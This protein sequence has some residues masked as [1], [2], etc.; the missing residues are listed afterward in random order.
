MTRDED[1]AQPARQPPLGRQ[2]F[3]LAPAGL[4]RGDALRP[5]RLNASS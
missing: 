4:E 5:A 1:R 2:L 3:Q